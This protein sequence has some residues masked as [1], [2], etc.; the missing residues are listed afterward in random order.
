MSVR[1][2]AAR[3]SV[4]LTTRDERHNILGFLGALPA[5]VE[6]VVVDASRDDTARLIA[7][8]RPD[9]TR[10]I[11]SAVPLTEARQLAAEAASGDW[12]L[13]TDA[14]VRF[15]PGYFT[16]LEAALATGAFDAFYG[17]KRA[18]AE[19]GGYSVLFV[20]GQAWLDRAGIA[21]ASG[22]NM[23]VRRD[24]FASVGGFA[25]D[26]PVNEDTELAMRL[27]RLGFRVSYRAELGVVSLDDRRLRAGA[28]RKLLHSLARCAVL[29]VGQRLWL[30]RRLLTHDWGYWRQRNGAAWSPMPEGPAGPIGA[31]R[32][33]GDA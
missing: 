16:R 17:P 9:R 14:D 24:T 26:L 8:Q 7:E 29:L 31:N 25:R 18:T 22:S 2:A 10:I 11:H 23:G 27:R 6:L 3:V 4:L 19:F 20:R 28:V 13:I 33:A 30:P 1:P 21:A 12:L 5:D 32:D 15:E